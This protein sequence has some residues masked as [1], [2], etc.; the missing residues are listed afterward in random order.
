M[1]YSFLLILASLTFAAVGQ[2]FLKIGAN[3]LG[4]LGGEAA[5]RAFEVAWK[6][7]TN[8]WLVTGLT[9]Y[10][11]GAVTWI[12]VL[13]RVQ[14]TWAYP[15]LAL[16]QVLVLLVGLLFLGEHVSMLRWGGVLLIVTGVFMVSRS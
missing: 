10:G 11:L 13:T 14:L 9:C 2:Y 5:G 8:P 6:A 1:L 16:N 7:A 12:I 3:E 15:M 4:A